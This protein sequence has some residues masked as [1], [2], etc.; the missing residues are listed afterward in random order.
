MECIVSVKYAGLVVF[1]YLLGSIP[2]GVVL[3]RRYTAVDVR[4]AGSKNIGATNVLRTAGLGLGILTLIGDL[5]KG[6]LP[7]WLAVKMIGHPESLNAVFVSAVALGAFAGHLYPVYLKFT[8]GGK[9]VATAAGCFL[10]IS[11]GATGIV[12]LIFILFAGVANRVSV[13]SL[14][15]VAA[16]APAVWWETNTVTFTACALVMAV[17]IFVRH[18]ENIRRLISGTEPAIWG[19]KAKQRQ[20]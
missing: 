6:A 3:T 12:L 16:L 4:Q 18:R 9:G 19:K 2:W 7:V 15:A 17:F 8:T 20:G 13:G 5:S 10:I 1:A 11:P 14:V